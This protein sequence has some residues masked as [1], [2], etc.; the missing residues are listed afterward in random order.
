MH[1]RRENPICQNRLSVVV[2]EVQDVTLGVVSE[3]ATRT[4]TL[5]NLKDVRLRM[6]NATVEA[7]PRNL[8]FVSFFCRVRATQIGRRTVVHVVRGVLVV[9]GFSQRCHKHRL[10]AVDGGFMPRSSIDYTDSIV[11]GIV[12][13]G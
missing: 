7:V 12:V 3:T 5:T 9:E 10:V 6:F 2:D 13:Y 1:V 4:T 8:D 11:E